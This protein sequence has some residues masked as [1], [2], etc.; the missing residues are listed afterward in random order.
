MT[1][2]TWGV[3]VAVSL[4]MLP[5]GFI[6]AASP[7]PL[8][9]IALLPIPPLIPRSINPNAELPGPRKKTETEGRN[10]EINLILA[11]AQNAQLSKL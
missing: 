4:A 7:P 1:F 5:A 3:V 8:I 2:P 9:L 11:L 6:F 10:R